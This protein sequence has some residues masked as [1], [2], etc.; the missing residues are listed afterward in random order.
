[1]GCATVPS[2]FFAVVLSMLRRS[3]S[4]EEIPYRTVGLAAPGRKSL[5]PAQKA[6]MFP[7]TCGSVNGPRRARVPRTSHRF[8]PILSNRFEAKGRTARSFR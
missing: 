8:V 6:N 3:S 5:T 7:V 4:D 2:V 1:M